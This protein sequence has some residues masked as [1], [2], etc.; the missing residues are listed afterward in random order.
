MGVILLFLD[1]VMIPLYYFFFVFH[2][3]LLSSEF[4][5]CNF[6]EWVSSLL[7]LDW[8]DPLLVCF[9]FLVFCNFLYQLISSTFSGYQISLK[10]QIAELCHF[11]SLFNSLL[12]PLNSDAVKNSILDQCTGCPV[13]SLIFSYSL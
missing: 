3:I 8:Y 5:T 1:C 9:F 10:T 13:Y 12:S 7:F 6:K 2:K 4:Y 11:M